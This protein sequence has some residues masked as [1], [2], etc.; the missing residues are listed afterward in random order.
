MSTKDIYSALKE[1]LVNGSFGV[2]MVLPNIPYAPVINAPYAEVYFLPAQPDAASLG[3]GK[4]ESVTGI[5]QLTLYF[6]V[7]RGDGLMLDT[8]DLLKN[9]FLRGKDFEYGESCV[10]V[11]SAGVSGSPGVKGK[12]FTQVFDIEWSAYEFV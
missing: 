10:R 5:L 3:T 1:E 4:A 2:H 11:E 8:I 7:E 6:P 12:W 9:T